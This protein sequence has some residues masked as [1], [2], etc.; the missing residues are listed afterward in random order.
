MMGSGKS[1]LSHL[2]YEK[3]GF[4]I[5]D[6]DTMIEAQEQCSINEMFGSKG[7]SYFRML[8]KQFL[9]T[10]NESQSI[11]STGGGMVV[12]DENIEKLREIGQVFYLKGTV[13]TLKKRLMSQTENRPLLDEHALEDQLSHLLTKREAMYTRAAHHIVDI[14]DKSAEVIVSEIYAILRELDYKFLV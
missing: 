9:E 12:Q 13:E 2:L 8:E 7:E 4:K 3:T 11:I 14:D 10:L 5:I 6:T 1:T